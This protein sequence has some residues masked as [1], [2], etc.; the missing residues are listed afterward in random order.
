MKKNKI[1]LNITSF[2]CFV[3]F[4]I[5]IFTLVFIPIGVYCFLAGKNFSYKAEHQ[6]D[7][8]RFDN[9][10]FKRYMIFTC[11]FVFPFGLLSIIPYISLATNNITITTME[12]QN[13]S[14]RTENS[15]GTTTLKFSFTNNESSNSQESSSENNNETRIEETEEEKI[16]K[17]KKLENF[18]EKGFITEEEL[19]QARE[20]IFGKKEN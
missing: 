9:K 10:Q 3:Y 13:Q 1:L 14:E 17:F 5:Y 8:M 12:S 6:D 20:Q 19:E 2:F 15:D 7:V 16:E 4:A 18:K 11:I